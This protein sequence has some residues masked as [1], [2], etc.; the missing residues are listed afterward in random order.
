V[1]G[2]RSFRLYVAPCSWAAP[3]LSCS[4][5]RRLSEFVS[6]T[7]NLPTPTKLE[8]LR[9]QL[10]DVHDKIETAS[11]QVLAASD[12]RKEQEFTYEHGAAVVAFGRDVQDLAKSL[13]ELGMMVELTSLKDLRANRREGNQENVS[14]FDELGTAN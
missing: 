13:L 10:A 8:S 5:P 12:F 3:S 7:P 11:H 9:S 14:K 6:D 1:I 4:G 2:A